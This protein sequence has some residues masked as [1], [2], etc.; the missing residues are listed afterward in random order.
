MTN[1]F[2]DELAMMAFGRT[3][4]DAKSEG[5]CIKCGEPVGEFRDE[6]SRREYRITQLC[7]KCQDEIY[8]WLEDESEA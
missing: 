4:T 6:L 7:Q 1:N 3:K 5:V 2:I 8:E